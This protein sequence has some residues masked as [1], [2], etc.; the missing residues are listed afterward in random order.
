MAGNPARRGLFECFN[1]PSSLDLGPLGSN[2]FEKL[3]AEASARCEQES[4]ADPKNYKAHCDK[5]DYFSTPCQKPTLDSQMASTPKIFKGQ[6]ILSPETFTSEQELVTL[7]RGALTKSR[8]KQFNDDTSP[9]LN[10]SSK[11]SPA[12]LRDIC[13]TPCRANNYDAVGCLLDTPKIFLVDDAK[14]ISESLGVTV[15]PDVSWSSSLN[16]PTTGTPTLIQS[17][18]K[19]DVCQKRISEEESSIFVRKLFPC[20]T[21]TADSGS[22]VIPVACEDEQKISTFVK[23]YD[24]NEE[25][26]CLKNT[27]GS[28]EG[29]GQGAASTPW[30]QTLPDALQDGEV[31]KSVASVLH[32]AEDVLSIFFRNSTNSGLRQVTSKNSRKRESNC[33]PKNAQLKLPSTAVTQSCEEAGLSGALQKERPHLTKVTDCSDF[34]KQSWSEVRIS[35]NIE[36][37]QLSISELNVTQLEKTC[38]NVPCSSK[39]VA[40]SE[41][42]EPSEKEVNTNSPTRSIENDCRPVQIEVLTKNETILNSSDVI[43]GKYI[44]TNETDIVFHNEAN[45]SDCTI[46]VLLKQLPEYS[47]TDLLLLNIQ[48][49]EIK[50][51]TEKKNEDVETKEHDLQQNVQ[52]FTD[53]PSDNVDPLKQE[54]LLLCNNSAMSTTK[55]PP[56]KF[57][58][59]LQD[60][61]NSEEPKLTAGQSDSCKLSA[62]ASSADSSSKET[63]AVIVPIS[64]ETK[65]KAKINGC[66]NNQANPE[67]SADEVTAIVPLTAKYC[68]VSHPSVNVQ[69]KVSATACR[70]AAECLR[71][72]SV[73]NQLQGSKSDQESGMIKT[74]FKHDHPVVLPSDISGNDLIDDIHNSVKGSQSAE[75]NQCG[76]KSNTVKRTAREKQEG[77]TFAN[78]SAS[79]QSCELSNVTHSSS[80]KDESFVH[81]GFNTASNKIMVVSN[82]AIENVKLDEFSADTVM[83][84]SK[85]KESTS[86]KTQHQAPRKDSFSE[87]IDLSG[88]DIV[89]NTRTDPLSVSLDRSSDLSSLSHGSSS[90]SGFK[91]A[92]N[93]TIHVSSTNL[94]KVKLLFKEIDDIC[95]TD[96][97]SDNRSFEK[98]EVKYLCSKAEV[99][100]TSEFPMQ[101]DQIR[102]PCEQLANKQKIPE[103]SVILTASQKA[104]VVELCRFL[105]EAD[106]QFEFT[107]FRKAKKAA[108]DTGEDL[109]CST[110]DPELACSHA[111]I[112][113]ILKGV[114]FDDSF[115]TDYE[116]H[117]IL[118]P[119]LD[120]KTTNNYFPE[121]VSVSTFSSD[122]HFD[123]P[124]FEGFST[125]NGMKINTSK[126]FLKRGESFFDDI[127]VGCVP[128]KNP[129]LD[130]D[131][132]VT[133]LSGGL[134]V[135]KMVDAGNTSKVIQ[136]TVSKYHHSEQLEVGTI[137]K[138]GLLEGFHTVSGRKFSLSKKAMDK[139]N[140]YFEECFTENG[141][142]YGPEMLEKKHTS[143]P[144]EYYGTGVATGSNQT[145]QGVSPDSP[146]NNVIL[147]DDLQDVKG[148]IHITCTS[149][150]SL[151]FV[152]Q[153]LIGAQMSDGGIDGFTTLSGKR[154]I[155]QQ[156]SEAKAVALFS[157]EYLL[158]KPDHGNCFSNPQGSI[159]EDAMITPKSTRSMIAST[160]KRPGFHTVKD[161]RDGV[162]YSEA[163]KTDQGSELVSKVNTVTSSYMHSCGFQT[164]GGKFV[165][166]T[167][168]ATRAKDMFKDNDLD[169]KLTKNIAESAAISDVFNGSEFKT[170]Q[171]YRPDSKLQDDLNSKIDF[172]RKVKPMLSEQNITMNI[173]ERNSPDYNSPPNQPTHS[174]D[175]SLVSSVNIRPSNTD[176]QEQCLFNTSMALSSCQD[177]S[178]E[179]TTGHKDSTLEAGAI[180]RS[181]RDLD[182]GGILTSQ[183]CG[184][185]AASGKVAVSLQA[186]K[187][188]RENVSDL[189]LGSEELMALVDIGDVNSC[190]EQKCLL[191]LKQPNYKLPTLPTATFKTARGHALNISEESL[192]KARGMFSKLEEDYGSEIGKVQNSSICRKH[193]DALLTGDK[194]SETQKFTKSLETLQTTNISVQNQT[195][196]NC[197]EFSTA[198][199]K[200]VSVSEKALQDA[201]TVLKDCDKTAMSNLSTNLKEE[202][203]KATSSG[204]N[205]KS[206]SRFSIT[207]GK[208]VSLSEKAFRDA[209][210]MLGEFD[211]SFTNNL[212]TNFLEETAKAT[213]SGKNTKGCSVFST[214]S[215]KSVSVSEKALQDAKTVLK[216]CDE[217]ATSNLSTNLKEETP[218]AT[219][220]GQNTKGCCSGFSTARGKKVFVSE[221]ALREAK[222]ML[223][224]CDETVTNDLR[225]N[226]TEQTVK[227]TSSGQNAK[228]C[229][230]FS[231]PGGKSVSVSIKAFQEAKAM[232]EEFDGNVTSDSSTSFKEEIAQATSHSS[233]FSTA[234]GKRVSV[235]EKAFQEAKTVLKEF[236]ESSSDSKSHGSEQL[237][238]NISKTPGELD[239]ESKQLNTKYKELQ[240]SQ[241][242]PKGFGYLR[243]SKQANK[244]LSDAKVLSSV[245]QLNKEKTINM[246]TTA[247]GVKNK[248]MEAAVSDH[249]SSLTKDGSSSLLN[250]HTDCLNE[251]TE[252]QQ[253][254]IE[255]EA[256]ECTKALMDDVDL[257]DEKLLR[258]QRNQTGRTAG[259]NDT[260]CLS[261]LVKSFRNGKR[262]R[263]VGQDLKE[264]PP[265]KRQLLAEF[266][267]SIEQGKHSM[268]KA[269]VS[270]PGAL[271]DRRTFTYN[272]PLKPIVT[273]PFSYGEST[274]QNGQKSK[275]FEPQSVVPDKPFHEAKTVRTA[276][277]VP[278]FRTH[279]NSEIPRSSTSQEANGTTS[280]FVPPFKTKQASQVLKQSSLHINQANDNEHRNTT[281]QEADEVP[282]TFVPPFKTRQGSLKDCE[283]TANTFLDIPQ[284]TNEQETVTDKTNALDKTEN[285]MPVSIHSK[286]PSTSEEPETDD[287]QMVQNLHCARDMQ[288]MR[289]RKK[290]RQNI[291]PWPGSLFMAKTSGVARISLHTAV[292]AKPPASYSAEQLYRFGVSR[293][294]LQICSENAESFRFDLRDYFSRDL[295]KAGNGVQLADGGRL[296]PDD[297]GTAGKEEFYRALCDT[298]TVDSKLIS[299]SW[300]Y[301]H[302][303]WIVWKLAATEKAFPKVFGSKCLTP[304]R[305]LLQLKYRYDVE[306]DKSQRSAIKKITERDDTAAKTLVLCVSKILSTGSKPI[307]HSNRKSDNGAT[308]NK[309]LKKEVPVGIIEVTDGWYGI[310]VLLDPPLVA[311]LQKGKLAV[312]NKIVTHGA[313]LV[314]SQD[315]CTPLEAPE[316]LMLKISANSTRPA[317]WY[318]KL[319]FHRDPRPFR[320]PLSS[321]YSDGGTVGCVDV[322]ILRSYPI[323]WMEK[324]SNGVYLFRNDRAE[325][326]EAQRQAESQQNKMEALFTKLQAE[327][328]NEHEAKCKSKDK[329]RQR[330]SRQQIQSLQDGA[331]LY[332]AIESSSDPGYLEACLTDQ[333]LKAL[334][335]HRQVINE[336][337]QAKLQEE[338]RKA[339]E[340][341]KEDENGCSKRDVT[342]VWKL[343]VVDCRDHQSDTAYMLNIWRPMLELRSLIKEGCRY[344]LY[345]LSTSQSKGLSGSGVVQ[346][347]ATKKTQFQQLQASPE[348]LS[349]LY[350]PRQAVNFRLLSDPLFQPP[351]AEVDLVGYVISIEEKQG[352]AQVIYLAD[353]NQ[354]LVALKTWTSLKQLAAED[355]VKPLTL[356]AASNLQ[357]RHSRAADIPTVY[358][359]D[360]SVFSASPKE[361]HLQDACL[362]LKNTVQDIQH[363]CKECEEELKSIKTD[364]ASSLHSPGEFCTNPKRPNWKSENRNLV[365]PCLDNKTPQPSIYVFNS[366]AC[367]KSTQCVGV[368]ENQDPKSLKRR[369]G[370]DFLSCIPL[371]PPVTPVRNFVS[372]AINKAFRPPRRCETPV[373]ITNPGVTLNNSETTPCKTLAIPSPFAEDQWVDDEELAMINTQALLNGSGE[374]IKGE[375][376]V[377]AATTSR[378]TLIQSVCSQN[379]FSVDKPA[380]ERGLESRQSVGAQENGNQDEALQNGEQNKSVDP[381]LCQQKLQTRRKRKR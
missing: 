147:R 109:S 160:G 81:M 254:Y 14:R 243:S 294:M 282:R 279:S 168:E 137:N 341:A 275:R 209:T 48:M 153:D 17:K 19:E 12:F 191:E 112:S 179:N 69:R 255:Q 104:E 184:F 360:L 29:K 2:W 216:D 33:S 231:T 273:H 199:G 43:C 347:T 163:K 3:T 331:E 309:V 76:T 269:F 45:T 298:P 220:S 31:R 79:V 196:K 110:R 66:F 358:A 15:D 277:F 173:E 224:D 303:R 182:A 219:S 351:C 206:C 172:S 362:R 353:E 108:H 148:K 23:S 52:K 207:S 169:S 68:E 288:E 136:Q 129:A 40:S 126:E 73:T 198:S 285:G 75:L 41:T 301:N 159:T 80:K 25:S 293:H 308:P 5:G 82:R 89:R 355:I 212:G 180:K 106:S 16:T 333:Q 133:D 257:T 142:K 175:N 78:L 359:G 332:E 227:A 299:E 210:P 124:H 36:W 94:E 38:Y 374:D 177:A 30:K 58:Y 230:G 21:N 55:K 149:E 330:F 24:L 381:L 211:E 278:P 195:K 90:F 267:S 287:E 123:L 56:R 35:E 57:L 111:D 186:L 265:L 203:P 274:G 192:N 174:S 318:A 122:G 235:S 156:D 328:E 96:D 162:T 352:G 188:G 28:F 47:P 327:F 201:K 204:Q 342:P 357:W 370:L 375:S 226:F 304:E 280:T 380:P 200:K 258:I 228:D 10:A 91:T 20:Q 242:T 150:Q 118:N 53:V 248:S 8:R 378:S 140:A 146:Y 292:D 326:R 65:S 218:K 155:V 300:G 316:S 125:A 100:I 135:N 97:F 101:T 117:F 339:L 170:L 234:S 130:S 320:L 158:I 369:R 27:S 102:S 165:S 49:P 354:N 296:I 185:S 39:T 325:E 131:T 366:P 4:D 305:L 306:I 171:L 60:P 221:K 223:K 92:S 284:T 311:L 349:Q 259:V 11:E 7:E 264:E 127:D 315:A 67:V 297:K 6:G 363:F 61:L 93:S 343:Q 263:S 51:Q 324:K 208:G 116:E 249:Q 9:C 291:R 338:F 276:V 266:N 18:A 307:P 213:S 289:L 166:V 261:S 144:K 295:I 238:S 113:D 46:A 71:N 376:N 99:T 217:T 373:T 367:M 63:P 152:N 194:T 281:F 239:A 364:G 319:G 233:G 95:L 62:A 337:K 253:R 345:Q 115:N 321:L 251:C 323:Q 334:S 64:A 322:I 167:T 371:P 74:N 70:S 215:G 121:E 161:K 54:Q 283:H 329:K 87:C 244:T 344:R 368:A 241:Q 164:A 26:D 268:K 154:V 245:L 44:K 105:E 32:G 336:Q 246:V 262:I 260:S 120:K 190:N 34:V 13:K 138:E 346:L 145:T 312:G 310:N 237:I 84:M 178:F 83:D 229:Y 232:L 314:G 50:E 302:F 72:K 42:N 356:L 240:N 271:N 103:A 290:K 187:N 250:L 128:L 205:T 377:K 348:S 313:E 183:P 107:Q 119:V 77:T 88:N 270:S 181:H 151:A 286:Q 98:K 189:E 197:A 132:K 193:N 252:T 139:A 272:V 365:P 379:N 214:A 225:I 202:T 157:D 317:R 141:N 143:D 22:N 335:N 222:T 86:F 114:D 85:P 247:T 340:S 59:S 134:P 372:P 37:S 256:M 236:E 176:Q 361:V 350:H 1:A